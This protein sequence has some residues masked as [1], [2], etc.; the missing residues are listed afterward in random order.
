MDVVLG[1]AALHHSEDHLATLREARRVLKEGGQISICDVVLDSNLACWLNDFVDRYNPAGHQGRFIEEATIVSQ[2][3]QAGF[4]GIEAVVRQVPWIFER[5]EDIPVFFRG[6]FN[7]HCTDTEL[8]R[9]M[10]EYF[11]IAPARGHVELSWELLYL[12]AT[13]D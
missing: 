3:E 7:L 9:A 1:L 4:T 11:D 5:Q 10:A 2:M 13:T 8:Q 12:K 6:L